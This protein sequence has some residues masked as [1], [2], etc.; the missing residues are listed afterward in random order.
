[1]T[2]L[3][4]KIRG[5]ALLLLLS[6]GILGYAVDANAADLPLVN[7]QN[8]SLAGVETLSITYGADDVILRA[9]Q[10]GELVI[11]EYMQRDRSQY[12]ANVS[13]SAGT[14]NIKAGKRPWFSWLWKGARM[15]IYLPLSFRE[16][17]RI[18]NSSGTF[19]GEVDLLDYKTIDISVSSGSVF[20]NH[21]SAGT[22]SLRVASGELDIRSAGGD[23]FISVSSGRLQIDSLSGEDHRVR[24]SS[25]LTSIEKVR[26]RVDGHVSSGSLTVGDFSGGGGFELS[27]GNIKLDLKELLEDLR[28]TVS[29]GNVTMTIPR[30]LAFNLDAVTRSG[31][32]LVD[33][34]RENTIRVSGNS[35]VIRPVG[36]SPER[37]IYARTSSGSV[38]IN[39]DF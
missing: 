28:I 23:S 19:S 25:G 34:D 17:I 26:G 10:T 30:D 14:L 8:L 5:A 1:M 22:V 35:T 38:R 32:I 29:S 33:E 37:T 31:R 9:S 6:G 20:L 15:E 11:K 39:R 7:T 24:I 4:K 21:L 18:S 16:N 3:T 2:R 36:P 27:S 13:R 12:Y